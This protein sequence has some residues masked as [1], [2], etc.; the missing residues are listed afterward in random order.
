MIY[1]KAGAGKTIL[2]SYLIHRERN[3]GSLNVTALTLYHYFKFNDETKNTPLA[4]MKSILDQLYTITSETE[5]C[6]TLETEL[7]KLHSHRQCRFEDLWHVL[8]EVVRAEGIQIT[9]ILDAID[10]CKGSKLLIRELRKLTDDH[11]VKVII[12][13]RQQG[14]HSK[15]CDKAK[16]IIT[17]TESDVSQD[18]ICFVQHKVDK[19]ERLQRPGL[20][21]LKDKV[22]SILGMKEN[23]KGM[24]LWAYLM[25]KDLK[26][27]GN[28]AAIE[29]MMER[30]PSGLEDL[31]VKILAWLSQQPSE[32]QEL[33]RLVLDLIVASNR[34]L[35]FPELEQAL[36]IG[37][38]ELV[39][40]FED[41]NDA[42]YPPKLLIWSRKD[43]TRACGSFVTYSGEEDGD[44]IGLIHLTAR[45]FL[46]SA[47][48]RWNL[49]PSQE[50]FL[51]DVSK[52]QLRL[53]STCLELLNLESLQQGAASIV[54][55]SILRSPL[56]LSEHFARRFPLFEYAVI[57]WLETLLSDSTSPHLL[58]NSP[59]GHRLV[60][61]AE[62][63]LHSNFASTWMEHYIAQCGPEHGRHQIR[64]L[65]ESDVGFKSSTWETAAESALDTYC[66][67]LAHYPQAL[68]LCLQKESV[69]TNPSEKTPLS[70]SYQR[71]Q[72]FAS[73][74]DTAPTTALQIRKGVKDWIHYDEHMDI[75]LFIEPLCKNIELHCQHLG[76]GLRFRP[77]IVSPVHNSIGSWDFQSAAVSDDGS[78]IA[79]VF[80][81]IIAGRELYYWTVLWRIGR[82]PITSALDV[83]A[84]PIMVKDLQTIKWLLDIEKAYGSSLVS[85]CQNNFLIH[86]GGVWDIT[87]E[88]HITS[89]DFIFRPGA[90]M[91][92]T[93]TSFNGSG[94]ARLVERTTLEI[95]R[96]EFM[97]KECTIKLLWTHELL[98]AGTRDVRFL[99]CSES[100][101]KVFL[102][103]IA[104]NGYLAYHCL[105]RDQGRIRYT[106]LAAPKGEWLKYAQFTASGDKVIAIVDNIDEAVVVWALGH[107]SDEHWVFMSRTEIFRSDS[108]S[109]TISL[110][111]STFQHDE[112]ICVVTRN[113]EILRRPLTAISAEIDKAPRPYKIYRN[114]FIE[115]G[116]RLRLLITIQ[117]DYNDFRSP[118]SQT[119][120]PEPLPY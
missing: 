54:P 33:S 11:A 99:A 108:D 25:Y 87:K 95:Y 83:W 5:S 58:M 91:N 119:P 10:E 103:Y 88:N 113:G 79:A 49:C 40:A 57:Y 37:Q 1:G 9:I 27:M 32:Q 35:R 41:S 59:V 76:S 29:K 65:L 82:T 77:S 72:L 111:H 46:A 22:K 70:S 71:G 42:V 66:R 110:V 15:E 30:L 53:A 102:T 51:V 23:H 116:A 89:P 47:R 50:H 38:P 115:S 16:S 6:K 2:S 120:K 21:V 100:C 45:E 67:T 24:F 84:E 26:T 104:E 94:V 28:P 97:D 118:T 80:A 18:I 8:T 60:R 78:Y 12:I 93:W 64:C 85:L 39:S 96:F 68:H 20:E 74:I 105:T 117:N 98:P 44:T 34:A 73:F 3:K 62:A 107:G 81:F 86:P 19:I 36:K 114:R 17:I 90:V 7:L 69:S 31:Y 13:G 109:I 92:V 55:S 61:E 101:E 4:A 112:E 48:G 14:D 52:S 106:Q 56:A 63:L 75:L 43:I